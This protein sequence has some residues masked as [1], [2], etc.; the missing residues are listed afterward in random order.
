MKSDES[1]EIT[2]TIK[3]TM[4]DRWI[5]PF[6]SMLEQMENFGN[7]GNSGIIGIYSDGDG[8][9]RP[10]FETNL[11]YKKM[12]PKPKTQL[13]NGEYIYDADYDAPES[14]YLKHLKEE[15]ENVDREW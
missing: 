11:R 4:K 8:D 3:C 13:N 2:F 15:K 6:L 9:F 14:L 12:F 7:L 1:K 10:K 5:D